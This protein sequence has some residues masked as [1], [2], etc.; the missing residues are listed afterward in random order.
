MNLPIA[1]TRLRELLA[2]AFSTDE[3]LTQWPR[4]LTQELA[5]SRYSQ[6]QW[7]FQR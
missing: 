5:T 6:R 7:T 1:A 2:N 4:A 3:R